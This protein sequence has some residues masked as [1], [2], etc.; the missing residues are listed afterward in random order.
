MNKVERSALQYMWENTAYLVKCYW[1]QFIASVCSLTLAIACFF[2]VSSCQHIPLYDPL[3]G[4]YIDINLDMSPNVVVDGDV[5]SEATASSQRRI[6]GQVP[7]LM[8]VEVYDVE[9]HNLIMEDFLPVNGGFLDIGEGVYDIIVYGMKSDV[10]RVVNTGSMGSIKVATTKTAKSLMMTKTNEDGVKNIQYDIVYEPDHIYVGTA[11]NVVVYPKAEEKGITMLHLTAKTI[12]DSYTFQAID[13]SGIE[14]IGKLSCFITGQVPDKYLWDGRLSDEVAAIPMET[15]IDVDKATI[16]GAFNTFGK[17]P[18]MY[19]N[20]Y[21]NIL[22]TN[23]AGS[24]YQWIYDLSD[25]FNDVDNLNHKL[26]ISQH[27]DIPSADG[28]GFTPSVTDW[29][30]EVTEVPL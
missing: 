6:E 30:A 9:T 19:A 12:V 3:S 11:E 17:H 18:R 23:G 1:K 2:C 22:V 26:V 21:L 13:I 14:N 20:V 24:M 29:N 15:A 27:I 10:N 16:T 28:G 5:L 8:M 4:L 25:Q 7:D